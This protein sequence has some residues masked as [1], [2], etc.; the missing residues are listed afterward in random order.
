MIAATSLLY[1]CTQEQT[2]IEE[3][4]WQEVAIGANVLP[5]AILVPPNEGPKYEAR[6][7]ETFGRLELIGNDNEE[8]FIEESDHTCLEKQEELDSGIFQVE[9]FIQSDS[10][11]V[12][13]TKIP[14]GTESYWNV[15]ASIKVNDTQY[16][17]EQNPL[18][19]YNKEAILRMTEAINRIKAY[20]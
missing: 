15:Y 6:W 2:K 18:I 8:I 3:P 17:I 11:L 4:K 20:Q 10:I 5:L 7:N 1:A 9:Y 14:S 13:Q 16:S 19:A 12:Y